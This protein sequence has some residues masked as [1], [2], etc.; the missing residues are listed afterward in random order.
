MN[1]SGSEA[2]DE[3][4]E[5]VAKVD[6]ERDPDFSQ[7]G[8]KTLASVTLSMAHKSLRIECLSSFVE[9]LSHLPIM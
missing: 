7:V 8:Y 5:P 2:E 9:T 4:E 6:G 3:R 1:V